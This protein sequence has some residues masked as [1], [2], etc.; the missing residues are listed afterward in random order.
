MVL[1]FLMCK[2][3]F[4]QLFYKGNLGQVRVNIVVV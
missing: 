3:M 1:Q 2:L 4:G